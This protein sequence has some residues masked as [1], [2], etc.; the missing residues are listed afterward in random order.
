[1]KAKLLSLASFLLFV[2][3][4]ACSGGG[5]SSETSGQ[6]GVCPGPSTLGNYTLV[7]W[8]DLGMHCMDKDYSVFSI[9]PPYNVLHAQ[10]QP[11][12]GAVG[13]FRRHRHL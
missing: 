7:A 6:S 1:M 12:D 13:H 2:V 8:N 10:D 5:G 11:P 3:L 9:L 4:V